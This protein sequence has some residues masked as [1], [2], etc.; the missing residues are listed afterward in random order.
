LAVQSG[1]PGSE[2]STHPETDRNST[3][4]TEQRERY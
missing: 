3:N 2:H 1:E 4:P